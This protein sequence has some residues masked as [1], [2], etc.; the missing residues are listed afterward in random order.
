[1]TTWTLRSVTSSMFVNDNLLFNSSKVYWQQLKLSNPR[2]A[3][4]FEIANYSLIATESLNI[5]LFFPLVYVINETLRNRPIRQVTLLR[6]LVC[7]AMILIVCGVLLSTM[8]LFFL[9]IALLEDQSTLIPCTKFWPCYTFIGSY[10]GETVQNY[11]G[12][13]YGWIAAAVTTCFAIIA[14]FV[15]FVNRIAKDQ[16]LYMEIQ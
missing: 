7:F 6:W 15:A 13:S 8:I 1:V 2:T 12:P 16:N 11:W 10:N 3:V 14:V 4:I 9:P 5:L